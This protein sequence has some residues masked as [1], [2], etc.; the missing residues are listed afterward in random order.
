MGQTTDGRFRTA[1]LVEGHSDRVAVEALAS[2]LGRD[3]P[4]DAIS[5]VP[6][7]G[8]TNIRKFVEQLGPQ[9]LGVRI[10]GLCDVGEERH[11][12]HALER[13]GLGEDLTREAM[14]SLGFFVCIR[15]LEDEFIRALGVEAVERVI[16]QQGDLRAL[17]TFQNQPFQRDRTPE[18]QLRRFLGTMS[19]RKIHYAQSLV[20]A[21]DLR[22]IPRSLAG[23]L[24]YL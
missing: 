3:L 21:L 20:D 24:D 1:V 12:F 11:F 6:I 4:A 10:A 15:D 7:G 8:A 9:G 22:G 5:V 23:L 13:A 17:R 2:R 16:E 14:E 18:Q 19:G